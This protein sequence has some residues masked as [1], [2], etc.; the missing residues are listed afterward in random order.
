MKFKIVIKHIIVEEKELELSYDNANQ[1]LDDAGVWLKIFNEM[2]D[3][4]R[5][6]KQTIN[7]YALKS[8]TEVKDK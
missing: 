3:Q 5:T 8:I 7:N 6:D 4:T 2:A 1:A